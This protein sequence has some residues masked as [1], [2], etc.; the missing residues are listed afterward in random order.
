MS[1][2]EAGPEL[3]ADFPEPLRARAERDLGRLGVDVQTG[4]AAAALDADGLE[5][6]L[7]AA[8]VEA[9][10]VIWAAGVSASPLAR[11]LADAAGARLDRPGRLMVAGDLSL[12]GHPEVFAVGDMA[13]RR[14]RPRRRAR[15]DAAGPPRGAHDPR[16]REGPRRRPA[17]SATSTRAASR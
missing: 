13:A 3:L 16:P 5:L 11:A 4:A 2:L 6:A 17:R 1:L 14:R 8:R 7:R 9:R 15:G 12:P 10:T